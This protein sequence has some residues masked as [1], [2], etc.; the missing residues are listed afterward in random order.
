MVMYRFSRPARIAAGGF[1]V[2]VIVIVSIARAAAPPASTQP[3]SQPVDWFAMSPDEFAQC[4]DANRELPW[5]GIEDELMSAAILHETNRY[6]VAH[7]LPA[8][9]HMPKV[10]EVAAM[11]ADDM[12]AG[13]WFGHDNPD[14]PKKRTVLDRAKLLGLRP[15]FVA[16]NLV[17]EYGIRYAPGRKVYETRRRGHDGLSYRPNGELIPRHTYHSF[18]RQVVGRWIDSPHHRENIESKYPKFMG[19]IA[20]PGRSEDEVR[21]QKYYVAQVFFTPMPAR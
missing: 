13:G 12:S 14:D 9:R 2:A 17:I 3:S 1:A 15:M 6:R 18:A 5:E 10:D 16:E 8:M 4:A 11:H 7:G 20:R 21:F 19:G